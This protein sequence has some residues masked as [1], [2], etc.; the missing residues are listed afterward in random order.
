ME[1][2]ER[3]ELQLKT[4]HFIDVQYSDPYDCVVSRALRELFGRQAEVSPYD[5]AII[6]VDRVHSCD[7]D[8]PTLA[9]YTLSYGYLTC[10]EDT[11]NSQRSDDLEQVI[12]TITLTK[13]Q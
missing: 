6:D 12:N 5:A 7:H 11:N 9:T 2:P 13:V 3:I 10:R 8:Y 1:F 4:K